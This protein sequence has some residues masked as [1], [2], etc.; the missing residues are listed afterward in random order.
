MT[1]QGTL[2]TLVVGCIL[3][4]ATGCNGFTGADGLEVD[5]DGASAGSNLGNAPQTPA[6]QTINCAYPVASSFGPG[7]GQTIGSYVGYA[8]S[9]PAYESSPR[10]FDLSELYDCDGSKG[11]HGIMVLTSKFFCG[12]C[13]QE[14]S[15]LEAE[16]LHWDA[17][18]LGIEVVELLLND[19]QS[20]GST[21]TITGV[22]TWRDQFGLYSVT[23]AADT[24][25]SM[26]VGTSV[27]T[28]QMTIIDP[29][30][31]QVVMRQEG[32]GGSAQY[33]TLVDLATQ[34][35]LTAGQ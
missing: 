21:P 1:G 26:V 22:T 13:A 2:Q 35:K 4:A 20:D 19:P 17:L 9:L 31:M 14:A 5:D 15:E 28:P 11:I 27:G 32:W 24:S 12:P 25:F 10:R 23:V 8:A 34:N 7:E 18:G 30:T 6:P 29:R 33:Q 3:V 16:K